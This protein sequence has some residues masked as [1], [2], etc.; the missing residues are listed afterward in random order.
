MMDENSKTNL[1]VMITTNYDRDMPQSTGRNAAIQ[2][3][4]A[5][6]GLLNSGQQMLP[7]SMWLQQ[8]W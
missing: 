8:Q 3:G 6:S 5:V 7:C 1:A 4:A 2:A